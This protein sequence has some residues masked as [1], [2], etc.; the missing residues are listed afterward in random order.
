MKKMIK[1]TLSFALILCMTILLGPVTHSQAATVKISQTKLSLT[2]G[3]SKTLK[4]QN[5][6]KAATWRSNN[7]KVAKVTK[8]GKVTAVSTGTATITA[9]V[10]KK[11]YTCNEV[12][13]KSFKNGEKITFGTKAY[14]YSNEYSNELEDYS[15]QSKNFNTGMDAPTYIN[16]TYYDK[17]TKQNETYREYYY[18]EID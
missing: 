1:R 16:I 9:T 13:Y 10:S 15:Y 5:T 14:Y 12:V 6:I 11:T 3:K 4:N 2:V 18:K 8:T 17:Y 7:K